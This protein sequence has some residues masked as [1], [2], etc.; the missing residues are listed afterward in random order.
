MKHLHIAKKF[1]MFD[2][3]LG[4]FNRAGSNAF[5]VAQLYAEFVTV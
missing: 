1:I 4:Y 2:F 3:A 5:T